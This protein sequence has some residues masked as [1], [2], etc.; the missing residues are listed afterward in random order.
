[1]PFRLGLL[2]VLIILPPLLL[3]QEK[4]TAR[5]RYS[6]KGVRWI[7][8]TDL[9]NTV[10]ARKLD[11]SLVG[12]QLF[13]PQRSAFGAYTGNMGGAY[14]SYLFEPLRSN[15]FDLGLHAFDPYLFD[16]I[17]HYD[18]RSPYTDL[19]YVMGSL[20][21][22]KFRVSHFQNITPDF[23]MGLSFQ[24][25]SSEGVYNRYTTNH[26]NFLASGA[27]RSNKH[28]YLILFSVIYN[29]VKVQ[30][31]GGVAIDSLPDDLLF[32]KRA[33]PIQL[34]AAESRWRQTGINIT[35]AVDLGPRHVFQKNDSVSISL[36]VPKIRI[37]HS[38]RFQ[39]SYYVY[40]DL[41]PNKS[42]Y[43]NVFYTTHTLDSLNHEQIN[44]K[45]F[46]KF[47]GNESY[48][49]DTLIRNGRLLE[50]NLSHTLHNIYQEPISSIQIDSS[51][52]TLQAGFV[53]RND[54]L[55]RLGILYDSRIDYH[56]MGLR[57]TDYWAEGKLGYSLGWLS[58]MFGAG[59]GIQ[60]VPYIAN[61]IESNHYKW[62][63]SFKPEELQRLS[64][65]LKLDSIKLFIKAEYYKVFRY[66]Y[67]DTLAAP[68]QL[69]KAFEGVVLKLVKNFKW[70]NLHLFNTFAWQDVNVNEVRLPEFMGSHS[71]FFENQLFSGALRFSVGMDLLY[72][73]RAKMNAYSPAHGQFHLQETETVVGDPVLDVFVTVQIK[74]ARLFIKSEHVNQAQGFAYE[75]IP[76]YPMPDRGFKFGVNWRFYD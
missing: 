73:T 68:A 38:F 18:A 22:Q 37:G 13:N 1:M 16:E 8:S 76:H 72:F 42:F 28:R 53:L 20:Q 17:L 44:N 63:N 32:N 71:L 24:K 54:L 21:E 48:R 15:D 5:L 2:L 36:V 30:E 57:E 41:A 51:F 4:D 69:N 49:G 35:Q 56:L 62:T 6:A 33:A 19:Y 52:E 34:S 25:I 10:P 60:R 12:I 55:P 59:Q 47:L 40:E 75:A 74:R 9:L 67:W 50:F 65:R 31:S 26:S 29:R 39:R 64:F 27:Y 46:L 3:A 70:R 11:T 58:F 23:N 66:L 14:R 45:V 61:R 43:P 7:S